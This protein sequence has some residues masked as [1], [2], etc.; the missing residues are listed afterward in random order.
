MIR[1]IRTTILGLVLLVLP[2]S[3]TSQELRFTPFAGQSRGPGDVPVMVGLHVAWVPGPLGLRF[4]GA[5]DAP[6]SP[7]AERLGYERTSSLAAWSADVD[8]VLFGDR[9]GVG[10]G[11][12]GPSVFVG[13]GGYGYRGADGSLATVPVWSYG[14]GLARALTSWLSLDLEARRRTPIEV[15]TVGHEPGVG[16]GWEFRAGLSLRINRR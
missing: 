11:M 4:G 7:V 6:Y 13:L 14:G 9:L 10:L 2:V 3:G 5:L 15:W 8:V 1:T 12:L 16:D